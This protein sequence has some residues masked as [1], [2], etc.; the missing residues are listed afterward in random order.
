MAVLAASQ[1][2]E[3]RLFGYSHAKKHRASNS[4]SE[5]ILDSIS[6]SKNR[7]HPFFQSGLAEVTPSQPVDVMLIEY[8][9]QL[10]RHKLGI[11]DQ[12][13]FQELIPIHLQVRL[14]LF[15]LCVSFLCGRPEFT[16]D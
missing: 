8:F 9:D 14:N 3:T 13:V 1:Q 5:S 2:G 15:R 10:E 12:C 7:I 16:Q 6:I 4:I 11:E